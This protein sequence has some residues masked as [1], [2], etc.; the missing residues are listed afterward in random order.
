MGALRAE[1]SSN[2]HGYNGTITDLNSNVKELIGTSQAAPQS[3]IPG[4]STGT[5]VER[6]APVEC[7]SN[8]GG[9]GNYLGR[10]TMIDAQP[11]PL[12][13]ASGVTAVS[14]LGIVPL[15]FQDVHPVAKTDPPGGVGVTDPA[16]GTTKGRRVRWDFQ[17]SG[18]GEAIGDPRVENS[19]RVPLDISRVDDTGVEIRGPSG[20][21]Y[22]GD[23]LGGGTS[24]LVIQDSIGLQRTEGLSIGVDLG[25]QIGAKGVNVDLDVG[26]GK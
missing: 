10:R 9:E 12:R 3:Y 17:R 5:L 8:R 6:A 21:L 25:N 23:E 7:R 4:P 11:G 16:L 13:C 26:N 15:A 2:D 19:G 1:G 22:D 24:P 18:G 14:N 20:C